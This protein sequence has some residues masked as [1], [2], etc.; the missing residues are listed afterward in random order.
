MEIVILKEKIKNVINLV[1]RV[2]GK[3]SGLSILDKFLISTLKDNQIE[4]KATDLELGYTC[5]LPAQ[6]EK[7]G[8]VALPIKIFSDFISKFQEETVK[9]K[10]KDNNLEIIG[11]NSYSLIPT[12]DPEDF[13]IIPKTS[14]DK[15]ISMSFFDFQKSIERLLPVLK[16]SELKPELNGLYIY[17][18]DGDLKFVTT[19]SFRLAE[20][21]FEKGKFKTDQKEI[22][23][24][25]PKRIIQEVNNLKISKDS[26]IFIYFDENQI[27]FEVEN[28]FLITR[29]IN[30]EYPKYQEI[31]PKDFSIIFTI[32]YDEIYDA[33]NLNKVF[34][35][36]INEVTF[37]FKNNELLCETKN[38]LLGENTVILKPKIIK[39][40][41]DEFKIAFN[42][43]FFLDGLE[44]TQDDEVWIGFNNNEKPSLLRNPKEKD[45]F[46][47][48]MPVYV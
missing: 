4:I 23:L 30:L 25:V 45:F 40:D 24:Y 5:Y 37:N 34:A 48:L 18:D 31:I 35:S 15:K 16:S 22:S 17:L 19:D 7:E 3:K 47:I 26:E 2:G 1:E 14:R 20:K 36:K 32:N 13:P 42:I 38:E 9:L 11:K 29:L 39:K 43:D 27:E 10:L 21:T 46:Y 28:N 33:L 6:I 44:A 12:S 8:K 41:V